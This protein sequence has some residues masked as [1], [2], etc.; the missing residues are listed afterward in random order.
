[1]H[2]GSTPA[3]IASPNWK[4]GRWASGIRNLTLRNHFYAALGD[5]ELLR[6]Q[7]DVALI[8]G[9]IA[10]LLGQLPEATPI[11]EDQELRLL[12][13]TDRRQVALERQA[14][15]EQRLGLWIHFTK[16]QTVMM[17][18][19]NVL[20][21]ELRTADGQMDVVMLGRVQKRVE[22]LMAGLTMEQQ[23]LGNGETDDEI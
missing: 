16:Y 14:R 23:G 11:T 3:G 18:M 15:V 13:L 12:R 21:E 20:H 7:Q 2:G 10:D 22:A 9:M 6:T 4:T 5:P 8:D 1:M 19:V 17:G